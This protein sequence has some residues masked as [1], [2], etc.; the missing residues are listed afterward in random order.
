[1]RAENE[2]PGCAGCAAIVALACGVAFAALGCGGASAELR[3][4]YATE[5]ARCVAN[6]RAIVDRQ[7]TTRE[8]DLS[9]LDAE[10]ARCDAALVAVEEEH[11]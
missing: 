6:E 8:Q 2:L 3:T 1:M 11:R 10:R 5:M 4:A 9:D 7:G